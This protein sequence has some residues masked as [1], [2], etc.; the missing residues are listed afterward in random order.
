MSLLLQYLGFGLVSAAI[1]ALAAVGF[2]LQYEVTNVLNLAYGQVMTLGALAAYAVNRAGGGIWEMV[3]AGGL[4]GALFSML[5]N[6]TVIAPFTR[7]GLKLFGMIVVTLAISIVIGN[8]ALIAFGFG[9]FSYSLQTQ[10]T[11]FLGMTFTGEQLETIAL[12]V[13]AM[14]AVRVLLQRTRLGR[15]MRATST[16]PVLA[17]ACGI[18]TRLVADMAWGLS[19]VLCGVAGVTEAISVSAFSVTTG[20]GL[21]LTVVAAAVVGGIGQPYGAMLG[22]LLIGVVTSLVGGYANPSY[23]EISAFVILVAF[24]LFRPK[25]L[26]SGVVSERAVLV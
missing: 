23:T 8:L 11:S 7:R 19:G 22:A 17:R 1:L 3:V 16:D 18:N 24:L 5:L 21:L 26:L 20:D 25:G 9:T 10:M 6:R 14:I 4:S 12:A 2:T 13:A 15:A